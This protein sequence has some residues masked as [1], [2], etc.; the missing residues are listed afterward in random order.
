MPL[1]IPKILRIARVSERTG[2]PKSTI[3]QYI[4]EGRFPKPI[5]LGQRS[6]GWK[7]E[8]INDWINSRQRAE[9]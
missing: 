4:R 3:Y 7:E 5:P 2:L 8:E 1:Y 6:V 9:G